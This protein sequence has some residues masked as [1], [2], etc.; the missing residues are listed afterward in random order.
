MLLTPCCASFS[1]VSLP[2]HR[3]LWVRV[4]EGA[5]RLAPTPRTLIV[6]HRMRAL[7]GSLGAGAVVNEIRHFELFANGHVATVSLRRPDLIVERVTLIRELAEHATAAGAQILLGRLFR[8]LETHGKNL[9]LVMERGRGGGQEEVQAPTV[10][11]ADGV[12]SKVGQAAGWPQQPVVPLVQAIVRLSSSLPPDT[13][14]VWFVPEDTPSDGWRFL[15]LPP[16]SPYASSLMP[17]ALSSTPAT[18]TRPA[19]GTP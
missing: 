13:T 5:S 16:L 14:R 18:G 9:T 15:H 3:G 8:G 19:Q 7:L 10:V 2:V 11:G 17:S 12:F 6:T 1:I 4:F